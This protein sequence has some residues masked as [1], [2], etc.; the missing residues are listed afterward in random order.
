MMKIVLEKPSQPADLAYL[1][2]T[3]YHLFPGGRKK[4]A[5]I[6]QALEELKKKG[7]V[8]VLDVGCGNGSI[9]FPIG[10][11]GYDILGIDLS[12]E[13]IRFAAGKNKFKNVRF[14]QHDLTAGPPPEKF[15]FVICSEV[16][17]H[18]YHPEVLLKAI[19]RVMEPGGT[20]FITVPNGYGPR[21][22]LG[23]TE[24]RL[25]QIPGL[26]NVVEATRGLLRM[27]TEKEKHQMHTSNPDQGHVQK[28]TPKKLKSTIESTGFSVAGWIGSFWIFSLFGNAKAGTGWVAQLDSWFG[29]NLPAVFASGWYILCTYSEKLASSML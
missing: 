6:V 20:L 27:K 22:V 25:R 17:E 2:H 12:E 29:E 13:S 19:A 11:L 10:S 26:K 4:L 14:K 15:S 5:C 8:K 9:T 18:L 21:E 1:Q 23:R 24:K 7:P 28:F 3:D 16:L